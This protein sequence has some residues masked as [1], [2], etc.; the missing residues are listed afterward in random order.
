MSFTRAGQ[1]G[2]HTID[3]AGSGIPLAATPVR[4]KNPD[5]TLATL[6]TDDTKGTQASNPTTTDALGNLTI[7]ADP[8]VYKLV[9]VVNGVEQSPLDIEVQPDPNDLVHTAGAQTVA[10]VKTFSDD[11]VFNDDAIPEAKVDGLTE[12]LAA[13]AADSGVVHLAGSETITGAKTFDILPLGIFPDVT[14]NGL[15][16]V[17]DDETPQWSTSRGILASAYDS[18]ADAVAVAETDHVAL[19]IDGD[20]AVAANTTI[21]EAVLDFKTCNGRFVVDSGITVSVLPEAGIIAGKTQKIFAGEGN[22]E[23]L[24]GGFVHHNWWDGQ[25]TDDMSE[26]VNLGQALARNATEYHTWAEGDDETDTVFRSPLNLTRGTN[27]G[28]FNK[29]PKFRFHGLF[30]HD[31]DGDACFVDLSTNR[32]HR[33]YG[34]RSNRLVNEHRPN[35]GLLL[36]R[37]SS[38]GSA[39]EGIWEDVHI[40]G[41]FIQAGVYSHSVERMWWSKVRIDNSYTPPTLDSG[42]GGTVSYTAT[43]L[44]D[45]SKAWTVNEWAGHVVVAINPAMAS[46]TGQRVRGVV[47]SN[48]SDTLTVEMDWITTPNAGDAYLIVENGKGHGLQTASENVH[49]VTSPFVEI[50]TDR[51]TNSLWTAHDTRLQSQGT[52]PPLSLEGVQSFVGSQNYAL[53]S[54]YAEGGI[55]TDSALASVLA[56]IMESYN[57][58][59]SPG[60]ATLGKVQW[61]LV[62]KRSIGRSRFTTHMPASASVAGN[63]LGVAT[64]LR[65]L[66]AGESVLDLTLHGGTGVGIHCPG[67]NRELRDV[68]WSVR[69]V[70]GNLGSNEPRNITGTIQV[71]TEADYTGAPRPTN[72]LIGA[73]TNPSYNILNVEVVATADL[74]AAG[75]SQNGRVL[76]ENA[77][78]GDRN[79]IIYSN[80]ERFRIDGGAAF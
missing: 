30:A 59:P 37:G 44:T 18:L 77:G 17:S 27:L 13:K 35:V 26:R 33:L 67:V 25:D 15:V 24:R 14:T 65:D 61:G 53:G 56:V 29:K 45:S 78:A 8:G 1:W 43:T 66:Q 34:L 69:K 48:T 40:S 60:G 50:A 58:E 9:A 2:P 47:V 31:L 19:I 80:G 39:G 79:L 74:P 72:L 28:G 64:L 12:A 11:P 23:V 7:F 32:H 62:I 70:I 63:V 46:A 6:Y 41:E 54:A 57:V 68:N 51:V 4:I 52:G 71:G 73:S 36:A 49:G 10:G 22:V 16:L 75:A 5:L 76:I 55:V 3:R 42:S 21:T 38:G 20:L